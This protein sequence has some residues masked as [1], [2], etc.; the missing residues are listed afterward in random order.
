ML[1]IP[2]AARGCVTT[3]IATYNFLPTSNVGGSCGQQC[4][5]ESKHYDKPVSDLRLPLTSSRDK[6]VRRKLLLEA[7]CNLNFCVAGVNALCRE[8]LA[9]FLSAHDGFNCCCTLMTSKATRSRP[10]LLCDSCTG[11]LWLIQTRRCSF[12][13]WNLQPE[14]EKEMRAIF[15]CTLIAS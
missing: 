8:S 10:Q 3:R 1:K 13:S 2:Q 7:K 12:A 5:C 6:D 14:R 9:A 11:L 4:S 15:C